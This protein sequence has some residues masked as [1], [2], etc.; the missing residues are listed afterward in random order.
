MNVNLIYLPDRWIFRCRDERVSVIR[1]KINNRYKCISTNITTT[2]TTTTELHEIFGVTRKTL[3]QKFKS[4][5]CTCKSNT[6]LAKLTKR[7]TWLKSTSNEN[8]RTK[9]TL[10]SLLALRSPDTTLNK[11]REF[12]LIE[13]EH[14]S[15]SSIEKKKQFKIIS[16]LYDNKLK[17]KF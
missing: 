17:C 7:L 9:T 15:S 1:L 6:A 2:T 4:N 5:T 8:Y 10:I 14:H 3:K 13:T 16:Q 12:N 11:R